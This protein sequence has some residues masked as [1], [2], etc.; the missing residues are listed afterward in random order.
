IGPLSNCHA[1]KKRT[2]VTTRRHHTT[3]VLPCF[4]RQ[5]LFRR[6]RSGPVDLPSVTTGSRILV[7]SVMILHFHEAT[8]TDVCVGGRTQDPP[9][10]STCLLAAREVPARRL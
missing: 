9:S 8:P 4:S 2:S 7:N 5:L 1:S 6:S 3:T 10:R